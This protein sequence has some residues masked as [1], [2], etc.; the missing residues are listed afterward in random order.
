[1]FHH[2]HGSG[3][4]PGPGSI[5]ADCLHQ[6]I[7]HVS[8]LRP[9]LPAREFVEF[10]GNGSLSDDVTCLTFDDALRCQVDIAVPV[11]EDRGITGFF[12]IPTS[13]LTDQ[14]DLVEVYRHFRLTHFDGMAAFLET[15]EK[16]VDAA[17]GGRASMSVSDDVADSYLTDYPFYSREDR[18]FRFIRDRLLSRDDYGVVMASM[19]GSYG[20][21]PLG[22]S[23]MLY[24]DRV[25]IAELH[26]T[27]HVVGMHSHSHPPAIH[28][29]TADE[30]LFEWQTCRDILTD[31][32]GD[33]PTT[34]SHPFGRYDGVGLGILRELGVTVGFRANTAVPTATSRL[35]IP[36]TDH[37]N[38]VNEFGL[39]PD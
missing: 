39:R 19:M 20:Y 3:H 22:A 26:R 25:C 2:F 4:L 27:G 38:V 6:I 7:D 8:A 24:A 36:R 18:R 21:D 13:V 33:R 37:A 32:S 28:E 1:M 23:R 16:H 34:M 31:V 11:L 10:V 30:Q 12:F 15:F 17:L 14:P 29:L 5:S 35:E 9:I